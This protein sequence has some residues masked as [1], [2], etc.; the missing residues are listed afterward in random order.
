[1]L[2]DNL[3]L[4]SILGFIESFSATHYCRSCCSPKSELQKTTFESSESLRNPVNL[5]NYSETGIKKCCIF[6][7]VPSYHVAINS[8][9]DFMHDIV[10]GVARYDMALIINSLID[11]KYITLDILNTRIELFDY[12]MTEKRNTPPKINHNNLIKGSVIMSASEML[13][14]VRYFS[15]IIGELVP[16]HNEV[17]CVYILLRKIIDLCCARQIQPECSILFNS[18][19]AEHNCLYLVISKSTLKPKYHFMVH[20]GQLLLR[21]GPIKLTSS[22][23]FEAKHKILKAYANSITCRI[24]LGHTLSYK[25]QLQMASRFL[26]YKG[27]K[28]DLKHGPCSDI[29]SMPEF[30]F[31][32]LPPELKLDSLSPS[33][34]KY[35]GL[36]YKVGMVIVLR[37]NLTMYLFGEI[38]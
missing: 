10:E 30:P 35:K 33:W 13:C 37:V 2:G 23:R 12:G 5:R 21:N 27:L 7:E 16:R 6:N 24:N 1:M 31:V 8:T 20:Y 22:M 26:T 29:N 25:L 9:C 15:L 34:L 32:N 14:L 28:S 19:V 38:Q 11:L 3:G 17:W 36:Y 4:N 18:L